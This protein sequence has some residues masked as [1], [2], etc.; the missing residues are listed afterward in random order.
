MRPGTAITMTGLQFQ[1]N[2]GHAI[3]G[4]ACRQLRKYPDTGLTPLLSEPAMPGEL[5]MCG[6]PAPFTRRE[7]IS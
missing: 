5:S 3:T 2:E 1:Q 4:A 7:V 6:Y